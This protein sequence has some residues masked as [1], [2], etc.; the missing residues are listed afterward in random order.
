MTEVGPGVIR[1]DINVRSKHQASVDITYD[2]Q[3]YSIAYA[4]SENLKYD[5]EKGRYSSQLQLMGAKP[6]SADQD[7][8]RRGLSGAHRLDRADPGN[9]QTIV[10]MI[11]ADHPCLPGHFPGRPIVPAV[12]VLDE[13][14]AA[15]EAALPNRHVGMIEHAKFQGFVL[16]DRPFQITFKCAGEAAIDFT[17]KDVADDRS[18]ATGRLRLGPLDTS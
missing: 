2:G 10:V 3:G 6:G 8:I 18:L 13:V 14:R 7:R 11:P 12:L 15:I 17:C 16:P 5:A 9:E 1:G 4:G